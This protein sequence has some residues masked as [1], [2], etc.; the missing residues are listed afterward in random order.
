MPLRKVKKG[1]MMFSFLD[2]TFNS[3][4]G[5]C[6]YGCPYCYLRRW[7]LKKPRLDEKELKTDLGQ[8]NFIFCGSSI[9]AWGDSIP[10]D[11]ISKMLRHCSAYDNKYLFL[12]KNPNRY[13]EFLREKDNQGGLI[14]KDSTFGVTM[15]SNLDHFPG[16]PSMDS[17]LNGICKTREFGY[18]IFL[19]IEPLMAFDL[20]DFITMITDIDPKLIAIGAD[21]QRNG[22]PEPEPSEVALLIKMLSQKYKV[23]V[24]PN[25]RRLLP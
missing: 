7:P 24:K 23:V 15:E 25:L 21:S 1:G 12:S 6:E 11:W 22:L 2:Y 8:D 5:R 13:L 20:N 10:S 17:R 4:K 3:I 19:S 14:P 16:P 18:D 9:D